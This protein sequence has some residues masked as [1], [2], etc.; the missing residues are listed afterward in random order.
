MTKINRIHVF[1]CSFT[2]GDELIDH[3]IFSS[4]GNMEKIDRIKFSVGSKFENSYKSHISPEWRNEDGF[5]DYKR[6]TIEQKKFAWPAILERLSGISVINYAIPGTSNDLM[7]SQLDKLLSEGNI[8]DTDLVIIG[9]TS[10]NRVSYF[11]PYNNFSAET[12]HPLA[13]GQGRFTTKFTSEYIEKIMTKKYMVWKFHEAK[14][15]CKFYNSLIEN[16]VVFLETIHKSEHYYET[17]RDGSENQEFLN[18]LQWFETQYTN[19]LKTSFNNYIS[20]YRNINREPR[21]DVVHGK[22]HP[23]VEIQEKVAYDIYRE[24]QDR[25]QIGEILC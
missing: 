22:F 14:L 13:D 3:I 5:I 16:R 8:L 23:K 11:N 20:D 18:N 2:A 9:L 25:Y 24:L 1:G 6:V 12:Y 7:F 15:R 4:L 19:R 10:P 17:Y 21:Y